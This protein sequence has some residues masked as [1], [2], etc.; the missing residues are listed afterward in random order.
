MTTN[1]RK[2][3][4]T[5]KAA[6]LTKVLQEEQSKQHEALLSIP[7][8]DCVS[9]L[10][11]TSIADARSSLECDLHQREGKGYSVETLNAALRIEKK[12]GN[13]TSLIKL[14]TTHIA[15]REKLQHTDQTPAAL[16]TR[17]KNNS[18]I[19]ASTNTSISDD[20]LTRAVVTGHTACQTFARLSVLAAIY[21]GQKIAEKKA[22]LGHGNGFTQW[23]DSLPFTK[24][25]ASNYV[26]TAKEF[27]ERHPELAEEIRQLNLLPT[28][29]KQLAA[30]KA[31]QAITRKKSFLDIA[32]KVNAA[33]GGA[34]L[35]ELYEELGII[36]R[37]P[38][39]GGN[40]VILIWIRDHHP[41]LEGQVADVDDIPEELRED[42]EAFRQAYLDAHSVT[43]PKP[44]EWYQQ[45]WTDRIVSLREFVL[46][47]EEFKKLPEADLRVGYQSLKDCVNYLKKN[48]KF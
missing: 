15:K 1:K 12:N 41:E 24:M 37:R 25:T 21:T 20:P 28:G 16:K 14:L 3:Q 45:R 48:F 26:R 19:P 32:A 46:D 33:I 40:P 11:N 17:N 47:K 39:I 36:R 42:Y 43:A 6:P 38:K 5:K 22:A 35:T 23:R 18:S 4:P 13:R 34:T 9:R 2:K 10:I 7:K 29:S 27:G 31:A 30:G 8:P 44:I